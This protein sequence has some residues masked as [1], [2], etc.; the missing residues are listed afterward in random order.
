MQ[1]RAPR[2]TTRAPIVLTVR[3]M[4]RHFTVLNV[5]QTGAG[6]TGGKN[7][8]VGES[9]ILNHAGGWINA[10]VK[11]VNQSEVGVAFDREADT[12]DLYQLVHSSLSTDA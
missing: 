11:W 5:S 6:L 8:S 9:V 7:L 1:P 2:H 12:E 10:T 3:G 4:G